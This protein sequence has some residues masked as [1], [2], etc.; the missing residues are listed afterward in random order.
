MPYTHQV[1]IITKTH[2]KKK[3]CSKRSHVEIEDLSSNKEKKNLGTYKYNIST[4]AFS[5][6]ILEMLEMKR[7]VKVLP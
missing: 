1:I 2:L 4:D 6:P 3:M 7:R 5:V